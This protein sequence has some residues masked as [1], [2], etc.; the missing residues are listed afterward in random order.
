MYRSVRHTAAARRLVALFDLDVA[1]E[2]WALGYRFDVVVGGTTG[3]PVEE[4]G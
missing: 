4:P 1:E 2:G 3:T